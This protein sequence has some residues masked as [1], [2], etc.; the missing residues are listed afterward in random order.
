M[1]IGYIFECGIKG[2]DGQVCQYLMQ[3]IV[4]DIEAFCRFMDNKKNLLENCGPVASLLLKSCNYVVIIWDLFPAWREKGIRPCQ[5]IDRGKIFSSLKAENVPSDK[6][7]LV[8]IEE[9]LEAWVLADER[10]L[11]NVLSFYKHPHPFR[12]DPHFQESRQ[13]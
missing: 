8:C 13:N 11:K 2:A 4:P 10:A 3:K 7:A 5:K 6:V 12:E 9:E 1:R